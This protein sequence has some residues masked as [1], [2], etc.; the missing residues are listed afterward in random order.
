MARGRVRDVARKGQ[1]PTGSLLPHM[2][3][4]T[5]EYLL[6]AIK[7]DQEKA[8]RVVFNR[9][10]PMVLSF[11]RHFLGND[12]EEAAEDVF[13]KLWTGRKRF[14]CV[15]GSLKPLL[16]TLSRRTIIDRLKSRQPLREAER[17]SETLASP[18]PSPSD[19]AAFKDDAVLI[20][21]KIGRLPEKRGKIFRLS[22]YDGL[23]AKE[24]AIQEGIAETTVKKHIQLALED[25]RRA[26]SPKKSG[27]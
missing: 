17:L 24:I 21:E 1:I 16:Y 15:E 23:S 22:R 4:R 11:C 10:Y 14:Y 7:E 12:F 8:F 25:L 13:I 3:D 9:Y 19:I 20:R 27:N 6:A 5:D 2:K 26:D 18:D